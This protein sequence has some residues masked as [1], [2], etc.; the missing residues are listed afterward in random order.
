MLRSGWL[1]WRLSSQA[2]SCISLRI[3]S[4]RA[5][6]V[7]YWLGDNI[8]RIL[9]PVRFFVSDFLESILEMSSLIYYTGLRGRLEVSEAFL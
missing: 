6:F 1:Y 8:S 3:A 7:Q 2:E 5:V 9:G 4:W